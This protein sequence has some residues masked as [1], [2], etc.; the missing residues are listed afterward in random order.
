VSLPFES[1]N[2]RKFISI[3]GSIIARN[4]IPENTNY[5]S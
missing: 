1:N 2:D 3:T 4:Q 5:F